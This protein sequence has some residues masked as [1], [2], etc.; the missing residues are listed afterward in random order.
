[1]QLIPRKEYLDWLCCWQDK[2]II[3]V[4]SGVRR[5]GKSTM[6]TL[7]K[8]NLLKRGVD[9]KQIISINFEAMEFEALRDYH[10]LYQYIND[11]LQQECKNYI[12]LDEVQHC[13]EYQKAV[14]SLFIKD[15]C[16]IYL[17]GSN[18]YFMSG[19]L[20]TVL[21][22][23]YVEL[24]MLPLSFK[25]FVSSFAPE[26]VDISIQEKFNLYLNYGSFPFLARYN[27]FD[28]DA[29]NYLRD[30]YNTIILNDIVKRLKITDVNALDK[31]TKFIADNIGNIVSINKIANT[32]KS[33]GK[34]IDNKTVE[35]YLQGLVDAL[36]LYKAP[37]FNIKGKQ[38]LTNLPK[39]YIVDIGMRNILIRNKESDIGHIIENLAYLELMRRGYDVYVGDIDKGEVDFVAIKNNQT[40]YYQISATT[41]NPDTLARELAPLQ[42]VQDNY[43]KY[44]LTLDELFGEANYNG[45]QKK[46]LIKWLLE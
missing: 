36:F 4:V 18:A 25:E 37:R 6:F 16:D 30:V 11:H 45:I 44:L 23:R 14:D 31:V 7:F 43:P 12:F 15:N 34:S 32:L 19:E 40:E 29:Y 10:T 27:S 8:Q 3:K 13:T 28:S 21:S 35:K 20:A 9:E 26:N 33:G 5:C 38:L 41:L 46:N 2:Q 17:T 22:G 24:K 42:S 1:M 39:Y